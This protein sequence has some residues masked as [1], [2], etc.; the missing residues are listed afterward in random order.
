MFVNSVT[1]IY[2]Y[3]VWQVRIFALFIA[4]AEFLGFMP[5]LNVIKFIFKYVFVLVFI[6]T[7]D[8]IATMK[9]V[10]CMVTNINVGPPRPPLTNLT[11]EQMQE[12]NS[13]LA[14]SN[15]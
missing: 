9:Y 10:M 15:I 8:W 13:N 12:I 7:G 4:Q 2:I 3:L 14:F 5:F 6:I 1:F 11:E